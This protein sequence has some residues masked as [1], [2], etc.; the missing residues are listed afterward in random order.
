[1]QRFTICQPLNRRDRTTI[2]LAEQG[3]ATTGS[4][5]IKVDR[6]GATVTNTAAKLRTRQAKFIT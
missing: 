6:T 1:M 5:T 4:N 2:N 3:L